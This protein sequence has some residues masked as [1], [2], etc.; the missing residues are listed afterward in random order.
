VL[1]HAY[2][3]RVDCYDN[4]EPQTV[5]PAQS[6]FANRIDFLRALHADLVV[7]F[8]RRKVPHVGVEYPNL[9]RAKKNVNRHVGEVTGIIVSAALQAGA[10]VEK[11]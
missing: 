11:A 7:H 9:G 5:Q 10:S 1:C 4:D 6:S 8:R 3:D 2:A